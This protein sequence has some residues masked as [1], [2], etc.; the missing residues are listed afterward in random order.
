MLFGI[1]TEATVPLYALGSFFIFKPQNVVTDPHEAYRRQTDFQSKHGTRAMRLIEALGNG[2]ISTQNQ[3]K[4]Y[5]RVPE[6]AELYRPQYSSDINVYSR[7]N[8]YTPVFPV[9]S[10]YDPV[11]PS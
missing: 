4:R 8:R 5:P 10:K 1:E 3:V 6:Y 9:L 2:Y 7:L 11:F